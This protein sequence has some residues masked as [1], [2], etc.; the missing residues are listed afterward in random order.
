MRKYLDNNEEEVFES[1]EDFLK[2]EVNTLENRVFRLKNEKDR[3]QDVLKL[4]KGVF[5]NFNTFGH[6]TEKEAKNCLKEIESIKYY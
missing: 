1:E 6:I 5:E 4:C 3:L 2:N